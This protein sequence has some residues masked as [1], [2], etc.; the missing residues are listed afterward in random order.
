MRAKCEKY[1]SDK[2]Q[3]LKVTKRTNVGASTEGK[4]EAAKGI[5]K[6]RTKDENA[7]TEVRNREEV[8]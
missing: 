6:A 7:C 3:K 8:P 5:T 4:F 2:T 1:E